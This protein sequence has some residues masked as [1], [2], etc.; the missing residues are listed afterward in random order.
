VDEIIR[1]FDFVNVTVETQFPKFSRLRHRKQQLSEKC[2]L[3]IK[4]IIADTDSEKIESV[5]YRRT[6]TE[7]YMS[8][9]LNNVFMNY[10][11]IQL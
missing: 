11:I 4:T 10:F 1:V 5:C 2:S 9:T 6:C 8:L 3:R 7:H